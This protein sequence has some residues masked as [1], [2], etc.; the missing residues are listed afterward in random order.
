MPNYRRERVA[1]LLGR[2][3]GRM[4]STGEI[5]DPRVSSLVSIS[6]VEISRDLAYAKVFV[7][8]FGENAKAGA[9]AAG[10]NHAAGFIQGTVAKRIRL[11]VTPRLTFIA[12]HGI[13]D[14]FLINEK[15]KEALSG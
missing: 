9:A 10:L 14:G 8:S 2:E 11:R 6:R 12:D 7:S 5:K 15:I 3:L 1:Q 13:E 4:I